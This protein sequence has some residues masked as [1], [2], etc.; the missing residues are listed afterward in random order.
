[1]ASHSGLSI[2]ILYCHAL[3][4]EG[5]GRLLARE[6]GASVTYV[7]CADEDCLAKA[8][9]AEPGVVLVERCGA[10]DAIQVVAAFPDALVIDFEIGPGP[11][12]AYRRQQIPSNPAAI[13]QLVQRLRVGHPEVALEQPA[14][15][16]TEL[17][18]P[19]R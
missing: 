1:M 8:T 13:V 18:V 9:A 16:G 4:G 19:A 3:L 10:F 15:H 12:W 7:A 11:T 5:I 14:S 17:L 6:P 2:V